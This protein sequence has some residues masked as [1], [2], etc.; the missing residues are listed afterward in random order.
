MRILR[1]MARSSP[2]R[3]CKINRFE[4]KKGTG[5]GLGRTTPQSHL[6][7]VF[8]L[9]DLCLGCFFIRLACKKKKKAHSGI[10]ILLRPKKGFTITHTAC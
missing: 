6:S 2:S 1:A 9:L 7:F 10:R 4:R 8:L 5:P 3:S